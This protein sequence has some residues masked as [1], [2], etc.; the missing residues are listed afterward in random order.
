MVH[1]PQQFVYKKSSPIWRAGAWNGQSL[2]GVQTVA[3]RLKTY[4][5]DYTNESSLFSNTSVNNNDETSVI[6]TCTVGCGPST[7]CN[8]FNSVSECS[9][10]PG[11][12]PES[13]YD[14]AKSKCIEKRKE[15]HTCGKEVCLKSCNCTA[16]AS[17]DV[18]VGGR[19]CY[20]WF[21]ELNDVKQYHSVDG[22]DFYL[23]LDAA[24]LVTSGTSIRTLEANCQGTT[25]NTCDNNVQGMKRRGCGPSI[26]TI[27][28]VKM[29]FPMLEEPFVETSI[30]ESFPKSRS[31]G[32]HSLDSPG[33]RRRSS[34]IKGI[35]H[36]NVVTDQPMPV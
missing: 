10:L 9:C 15:L 21:S 25:N 24:E 28:H 31:D 6:S 32:I 13:P 8:T 5:M 22:Q 27:L 16:Y 30:R 26:N 33:L 12:E 7:I 1:R 14:D 34:S 2:T 4:E 19:G 29:S 18:N 11:Y 3:L 23:R 36:D 17:A 20:A 35:T